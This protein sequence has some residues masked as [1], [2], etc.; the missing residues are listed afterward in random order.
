MITGIKRRLK[1]PCVLVSELWQLFPCLSPTFF[2]Y[3]IE[4]ILKMGNCLSRSSAGSSVLSK[5]ADFAAL[6]SSSGHQMGSAAMTTQQRHHEQLTSNPSP[7]VAGAAAALG[8]QHMT[9]NLDM[10]RPGVFLPRAWTC[11][12]RACIALSLDMSRPGAHRLEPG[13]CHAERAKR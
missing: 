3:F 2:H 5:D 6:A 12:G 8:P 1:K 9:P 7:A 13:N 4:E 11:P 10:S